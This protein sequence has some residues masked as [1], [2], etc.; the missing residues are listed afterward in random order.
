[1]KL[2]DVLHFLV[3]ALSLSTVFITLVSYLMYKIR[4][5]PKSKNSNHEFKTEGRFFRK[6]TPGVSTQTIIDV[7]PPDDGRMVRF[8]SMPAFFGIL[9]LIIFL[10]L[11]FG[12]LV[13]QWPQ[14]S[15]P[16]LSDAEIQKRGLFKEF[17]L[18]PTV[19]NAKMA[20]YIS[21]SQVKHL[22]E[23]TELLKRRK[24]ALW[25]VKENQKTSGKFQI[26][27]D[28]WREFLKANKISFAETSNLDIN[29]ECSV[30]IIPQAKILSFKERESITAWLAAGKGIVA[31]GPIGILE[32]DG[33]LSNH[34]ISN[35]VF[36]LKFAANSES[37]ENFPTLFGADR[38]PWWNLPPGLLLEWFPTDNTYL[39]VSDEPST[40][41]AFEATFQGRFKQTR[42]NETSIRSVFRYTGDSRIA[43]LAMDPVGLERFSK[44]DSYYIASAL[45][46]TVNW[47]ARSPSSSVASWKSGS[48]SAVVLSVDSE[49]KFEG[50]LNLQMLFHK[51]GLPAT[52]FTVTNLLKEFPELALRF[53]PEMEIASH[54]VDHTILEKQDLATQF[55][56]IENARFD[57][58]EINRTRVTGFRPPEE[59]FDETTLNAALQNHVEY[60]FG[61]QQM[62][63][64]APVLISD[65]K[66]QFISRSGLDDFNLTTH[67][68]IHSGENLV[69]ALNHEK[70]RIDQLGGAYFINL[71]SQNFGQA[72]YLDWLADFLTGV[73]SGSSWSV[74]FRELTKWWA[75]RDRLDVHVD[76]TPTS[77]TLNAQNTASEAIDDVMIYWDRPAG[78]LVNS[79]GAITTDNQA[80]HVTKV[81]FKHIQPGETVSLAVKTAVEIRTPSSESK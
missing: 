63:R 18:N 30:A 38:A 11:I 26:A 69:S 4:Q 29:S 56:T 46:S 50:A 52:F 61:D 72:P 74:N 31:T 34:P 71:H 3:L 7:K 76:E 1:M 22:N 21:T 44:A 48:K 2:Q 73:K 60:F 6:Y 36:G 13:I 80:R 20:E 40:A 70:D 51:T 28:G 12:G 24:I 78:E 10:A 58:E 42:A 37:H 15:L 66:I 53:A 54:T 27:F 17:D 35:L 23:A 43:W 39:A 33:S 62:H 8:R 65:G 32:D 47:A 19:A 68:K 5:L 14:K 49:D 75:L 67:H 64:F 57:I 25:A 59:R 77:T 55:H 79:S 9:S 81:L 45:V 16:A 41:S